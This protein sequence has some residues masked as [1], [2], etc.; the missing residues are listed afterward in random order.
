MSLHFETIRWQN[1][2]STGNQFTEIKLNKSSS[3]LIVGENGAGKSTLLDAILFVLYGRPYRNINKPLL[4]NSITNKNCLVEIEFI[5]KRKKYLVRRGIKPAVFDIYCDGKLV[6]Q[7]STTKEYQD[8]FEKNVLGM[9]HKSFTQI[10]VIGSA[11]FTPFMQLRAHERRAVIEDLLDIEIFTSMYN[12]LRDKMAFNKG[13]ITD[14]KYQMDLLKQKIEMTHKH[15]NEIISLKNSDRENKL[16]FIE[17]LKTQNQ[18]KQN[19]ISVISETISG[20]QSLITDKKSTQDKITK[21]DSF[22]YKFMHKIDN[23]NKD[24]LFFRKND[25]CPTC[26]QL[27]DETFKSK[28]IE[29]KEKTINGLEDAIQKLKDE[30]E[31]VA[32]RLEEINNISYQMGDLNQKIMVINT[33][34]MSNN[35]QIKQISDKLNQ[36]VNDDIDFNEIEKYKKELKKKIDEYE[37][38]MNEKEKF[39]ISL[40]LLKDTGIKT[41][42]IKQYIP[43]INKLMNKYLATLDFFVQFQLD[44]NFNEKILSRFRDEFSYDSFSEG[45]KMRVDMALLFTWRAIAK[46][47]NSTTTN[48]LILDEVFD[49]SLDTNGTDEF[50]KM[51]SQLGSETNIFVI[52]HKGDTLYDKF[53]SNIRFEKVKNFSQIAR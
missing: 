34:I 14:C 29:D 40:S 19:Q 26:S 36:E 33:E 23:I 5:S 35:A 8:H 12:V 51:I 3:T 17:E 21:L 25:N 11:N 43:I 44:E 52:S 2:L 4:V 30:Q 49:S 10:V 28:N 37:T 16:Q 20:L 50:M 45:E 13:A 27:I 48:L 42:I 32:K 46:L 1:F 9:N 24:I 53:H 22:N 6:D 47:R 15:M 39:E 18:E 7:N 38:L 41:R 31:V